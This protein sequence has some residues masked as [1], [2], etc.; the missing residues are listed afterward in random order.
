MSEN[1]LRKMNSRLGYKMTK[2]LHQVGDNPVLCWYPNAGKDI[3]T[4]Y[5]LHDDKVDLFIYTDE[6]YKNYDTVYALPA[7][8]K[9][10]EQDPFVAHFKLKQITKKKFLD[11]GSASFVDWKVS[12]P[13]Q[14][15][16][17]APYYWLEFE[18]ENRLGELKQF[19][20]LFVGM[21]SDVFCAK[22]LYRYHAHI[23]YVI[24]KDNPLTH[25][26]YEPPQRGIWRFNTL[27]RLHARFLILSLQTDPAQWYGN[28]EVYK[29]NP[30]MAK[31]ILNPPY[32][33][34]FKDGVVVELDGIA[35][36]FKTVRS[37]PIYEGKEISYFNEEYSSNYF[38]I[39]EITDWP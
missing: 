17:E 29:Y 23:Q 15:D 16:D 25:I 14:D 18:I 28:K 33:D 12:K 35:V 6:L 39:N 5:L 21:R 34:I 32:Y 2:F 31:P 36:F 13:N 38:R 1:F 7:I 37:V 24:I 11:F 9:M 30:K 19:T 26:F 3:K 10:L 8:Q 20:F 22:Y 27:K 4:S